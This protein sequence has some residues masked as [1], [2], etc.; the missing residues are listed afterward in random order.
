[1]CQNEP[2]PLAMATSAVQKPGVLIFRWAKRADPRKSPG[3]AHEV[4]P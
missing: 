2:L 3:P 4:M 1:M